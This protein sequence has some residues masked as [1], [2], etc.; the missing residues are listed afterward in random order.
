MG[1]SYVQVYLDTTP[2]TATL[3]Y[4]ATTTMDSNEYI[5][6]TSNE[7]LAPNHEIVI[8]DSLNVSHPYTFSLQ[9]DKK[10]FVGSISFQSFPKGIATIKVRLF[11]KVM[12]KSETFEGTINILDPQLQG[13]KLSVSH[14]T[15]ANITLSITT[16]KIILQE[17]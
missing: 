10:G 13:L 2:P 1:N 7:E 17:N 12:N 3:D 9:N 15:R 16:Q 4:P 8:V 6:I 5:T 14:S 11:D